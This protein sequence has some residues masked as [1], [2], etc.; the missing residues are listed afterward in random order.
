MVS[1]SGGGGSTSHELRSPRTIELAPVIANITIPVPDRN[2][3]IREVPLS[4]P[5]VSPGIKTEM[6]EIVDNATEKAN[7]LNNKNVPANE[8]QNQVSAQISKAVNSATNTE[9]KNAMATQAQVQALTKT[10]T[11]TVTKT[12]IEPPKPPK[13]TPPPPFI[14]LPKL[15]GE[16]S[17]PEGDFT[18]AITLKLGA[19]HGEPVFHTLKQPYKKQSDLVTTVGVIPP[20]STLITGKGSA[21]KTARLITGKHGPARVDLDVG[22]QDLRITS[23]GRNVKLDFTPDPFSRTRHPIHVGRPGRGNGLV[24][25]KKG[26]IFHTKVRGN[27][28]LSRHPLGRRRA[29]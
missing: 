29:R 20:G 9:V 28:L 16:A 10:I 14:T 3:E 13:G 5:L 7:D 21:Q 22:F 4:S 25:R 24:S 17:G 18:G 11:K 27:T 6:A 8:I 19:L 23:R 12:K 2:G 26:K 1:K 15:Q